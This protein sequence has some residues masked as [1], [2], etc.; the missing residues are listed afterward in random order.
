MSTMNV[1]RA[2]GFIGCRGLMLSRIESLQTSGGGSHI[3]RRM[4]LKLFPT[5]RFYERLRRHLHSGHSGKLVF[6][7]RCSLECLLV[8]GECYSKLGYR[9]SQE[10][11]SETIPAYGRIQSIIKIGAIF[12]RYRKYRNCGEPGTAVP[13]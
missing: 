13:Q 2:A 3:F 6:Q 12:R 8:P 11:A 1:A 5:S 10:A 7:R 9:H 4:L